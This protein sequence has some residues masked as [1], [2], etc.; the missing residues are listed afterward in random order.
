MGSSL[1][2]AGLAVMSLFARPASH[3]LRHIFIHLA[4]GNLPRHKRYADLILDRYQWW[5]KNPGFKED[6]SAGPP[7]FEP[8]VISRV[9]NA[10]H[11]KLSDFCEIELVDGIGTLCVI[12]FF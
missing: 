10:S 1:R 9:R 3:V 2:M 4:K 8:V 6:G 7:C 12:Y 11:P 5:S